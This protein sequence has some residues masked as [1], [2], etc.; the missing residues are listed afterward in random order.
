MGSTNHGTQDITY[1][2]FEEATADDFNKKDVQIRPIGIYKGGY[3]TRVSDVEVTLSAMSLAIGDGTHQVNVRATAAATLNTS[4][5]DAGNIAEATPY[6]VL[7]WAFVEALNNYV[8]V[9]A[10]AALT[11]AGGLQ[12]NDIVI[13][14]CNFTGATLSGTFDYADRTFLHTQ[15]LFLKVE[16]ASGMYVRLR[17]GKIQDGSQYIHIP[18]QLVGPFSV[19]SAPNSRID[20]V[21]IATDGTATIAA[22]QVNVSPSAPDY[23]YKLVVAEVTIVN[24]D[25]SIPASRIN[26]VRSFIAPR[27]EA[28][29]LGTVFGSRASRSRN[30]TYRAAT[31]GFIVAHGKLEDSRVR[32]YVN[33]YS[34]PTTTRG[35][36]RSYTNDERGT[37]TI[38]V[39]KNEYYRVGG[40]NVNMNIYWMPMGS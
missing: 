20:L 28:Y 36:M 33:T 39:K 13:G 7:R 22:G 4:T 31:D 40:T 5:L 10:L 1:E 25:S 23:G 27:T 18:E 30:K 11:V 9:H 38:P 3:L 37:L 6:L 29:T 34:P 26:D 32:V 15:D 12:S 2:Y 8:E 17:A 16:V 14:K 24:G 19:P 35:D 21:Y